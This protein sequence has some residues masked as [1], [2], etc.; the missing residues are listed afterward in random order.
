[1]IR[2][3]LLLFLSIIFVSALPTKD[4]N[5]CDTIKVSVEIK[6]LR[7]DSSKVTLK[8]RNAVKPVHYVFYRKTGDLLSNVF[9]SNS[10]S[11]HEKGTF[12]YSIV[13]GNGCKV[14][15]EFKVD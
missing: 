11:L 13:D 4:L 2:T 8:V 10:I 3:L 15:S 5:N 6:T 14:K 7:D 1:M 9:T 12:Y